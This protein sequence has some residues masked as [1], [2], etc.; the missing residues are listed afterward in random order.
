[1]ATTEEVQAERERVDA[2]R[3]RIREARAAKAGSGAVEAVNDVKLEALRK[4][5]DNLEAELASLTGS[6]AEAPAEAP[7]EPQSPV[8]GGTPIENDPAAAEA[9]A[10]QAVEGTEPE[11]AEGRRNRR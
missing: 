1:M 6:A 10:E 11:Q 5:G 3:Q 2:L 9:A 8:E 4:E 7:A